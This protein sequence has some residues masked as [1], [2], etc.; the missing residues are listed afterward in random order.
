MRP[1]GEQI[2]LTTSG[3]VRNLDGTVTD[4]QLLADAVDQ[5]DIVTRFV[6]TEA[7]I[8]QAISELNT[9]GG[10]IIVI[11]GTI[12]LTSNKTWD[13]SN[14]MVRGDPI[15][16]YSGLPPKRIDFNGYVVTLS[17]VGCDFQDIVLNG[18]LSDIGTMSVESFSATSTI[19]LESGEG[20]LSAQFKAGNQLV[21]TGATNGANNGTFT[22]ASATWNGTNTVITISE[23]TLVTEAASPAAMRVGSQQLFGASQGTSGESS[24]TYQFVRSQFRNCISGIGTGAEID[25][26][27]LNNATDYDKYVTVRFQGV[28]LHTDGMSSF[29]RLYG[30]IVNYGAMGAP[31]DYD[32][33]TSYMF[34]QDCPEGNWANRNAFGARSDTSPA[35]GSWIWHDPSCQI[36][37]ITNLNGEVSTDGNQ[38][39]F[40]T[41]GAA[42]NLSD[43]TGGLFIITGTGTKTANPGTL[44][45]GSNAVAGTWFDFTRLEEGDWNIVAPSGVTIR[46]EGATYI[47]ESFTIVG[48]PWVRYRFT[49][50]GVDEWMLNGFHD[51][52]LDTTGEPMGFPVSDDTYTVLSWDDGTTTF[53][54]APVGTSFDVWVRGRRYRKTSAESVV[55]DGT[56]FTIAEG[57][58]FFYYDADGVLTTS[59]TPW[60][61]SQTAPI[62]LIN[63]DA[64]NSKALLGGYLDERHGLTMSWATHQYNH[65]TRSTQYSSGLGLTVSLD[66]S[67]IG[68]T[69]SDVE[70][71]IS[72]GVLYDE[73]LRIDI[74]DGAGSGRFEQELD[75]VA[76]LPLLYK[77]GAAGNWRE[78]VAT[79]VPL[80]LTGVGGEDRAAYND[81]DAGGSGVWGLTETPNNDFFDLIVIGQNS[82]NEPCAVILGQTF[83]GTVG[84]A[85]SANPL[86]TLDLSNL[87]FQEV[88]YLYRIIVQ[89]NE[90]YGG[91]YRS[92]YRSP[93]ADFRR[94]DLG[95]PAGATLPT[96]HNTLSNRDVAGAHPTL[97]IETDVANFTTAFGATETDQELVNA[98]ADKKIRRVVLPTEDLVSIAAAAGANTELILADGTHDISTNPLVLN[99]KTNF[100]IRGSRAAVITSSLTTGAVID[101]DD[102]TDVHL[103]GFRITTVT[104]GDII[105]VGGTNS[106]FHVRHIEAT[107]THATLSADFIDMSGTTTAQDTITV[108]SCSVGGDITSFFR[109]ATAHASGT[110]VQGIRIRSNTVNT[111]TKVDDGIIISNSSDGTVFALIADVN[112]INGF[113]NGITV[114]DLQA[115]TIFTNSIANGGA[116]ATDAGIEVGAGCQSIRINTNSILNQTGIGIL[117]AGG[118]NATANEINACTDHGISVS[119]GSGDT[120]ES[121][122][123]LSVG[124][125]GISVHTAATQCRVINNYVYDNTAG[126]GIEVVSGVEHEIVNNRIDQA[127]AQ[128]IFLNSGRVRCK[129]SLNTIIDPGNN[130]FDIQ[131]GANNCTVTGNLVYNASGDGLNVDADGATVQGNYVEGCSGNGIEIGDN[132]N[133]TNN[134]TCQGNTCTDNTGDGIAVRATNSNVTGNLTYNN[135]VY[136][137]AEEGDNPPVP[138]GNH[139]ADNRSFG[140]TTGQFSFAVGTNRTF[141]LEGPGT[142]TILDD[143]LLAYD[144]TSG[145]LTKPVGLSMDIAG[146]ADGQVLQRSGTAIVGTAAGTGDVTAAANIADNALTKGDG[147]AKGIQQTGI[148]CDDSNNLTGVGTINTIDLA[149]H[150]A[151]HEDGGADEIEVEDLATSGATGTVPVAQSDGSLLMTDLDDVVGGVQARKLAEYLADSFAVTN[152]SDWGTVSTPAPVVDDPT[153]GSIAVARFDDT[154]EWGVG[155]EV[156]VPTGATDIYFVICH[157]AETGP[158]GDATVDWRLRFRAVPDN[159]AVPGSWTTVDMDEATIESGNVYFRYTVRRFKLS[160]I[161]MTAGQQY[162]LQWTRYVGGT[163]TLVDDWFC[164]GIN[165]YVDHDGIRWFAADTMQSILN[166]DWPT[167]VGNAEIVTDSNNAAFKPRS[168]DDTDEQGCGIIR[169]VPRGVA[170][171][172]LHTLSRAETAPVA[173]QTVAV[174]LRYRLIA[175]NGAVGSWQSYDL[176][177]DVGIPTNELWQEDSWVVD[178]SGLTTPIVPG[179]KYQFVVSRNTGDAGD[180]LTDPWDVL[181][182]GFEY[183]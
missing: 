4:V 18:T 83:Y 51:L 42:Q 26:S 88:R 125:D 5:L 152:V 101:V 105:N 45:S 91:T 122:K 30:L 56:D 24:R 58:W 134:V 41:D 118:A 159:A 89:T 75:P 109:L 29:N 162:Y 147:G 66:P 81:P 40:V 112:E 135:G 123:I 79:N 69:D 172:E 168:F 71:A 6:A 70:V 128:G 21:T 84:A 90:G 171:M 63:W 149:A 137:V 175:D 126:Y 145:R 44:A 102:A 14:I 54:I 138:D 111:D 141:G 10:G 35:S 85:R 166:T 140:N 55:G 95:S 64:T 127:A 59:Q 164:A 163:D 129:L 97:A 72:D 7:E 1:R 110:V 157:R 142:G 116:A 124:Q 36:V 86:A 92:R 94:L 117:S 174:T 93:V 161:G 176:P 16:H 143:G 46:Y 136:G 120:F 57:L 13:L 98:I 76:Y 106:R 173:A 49:N 114:S 155:M 139:F 170:T 73:D 103:E 60:D 25:L 2:R 33:D 28:T 67:T 82:Y 23:T 61:L 181:M 50:I 160:T 144:G 104:D 179:S 32:I 167:G 68:L 77:D 31:D 130:G 96:D 132:D 38:P 43:H 131:E 99:G 148:S 146:I 115:A 182:F 48:H 22:I 169:T 9:V 133:L 183:Y 158:T 100:T 80:V 74:T 47:G 17:G 165:V 113:V 39:V 78:K 15:G 151:R 62:A 19:T 119:G 52:A 37:E 3:F 20:D 34:V 12:T 153:N 121:N 87:P 11:T 156:Y 53:Q 150:G 180:T 154:E 107:N 27:G 178:L 65:L 108:E 8:D 177:T